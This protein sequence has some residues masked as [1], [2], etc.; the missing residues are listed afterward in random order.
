M[1]KKDK[2]Q[3]EMQMFDAMPGADPIEPDPEPIDL[4]FGLE[5]NDDEI[6]TMADV[7]NEDEVE[8]T[9]E[10]EVAE[11]VEEVSEEEVAD[12]ME[13]KPPILQTMHLSH[14]RRRGTDERRRK[15]RR[16]SCTR[17]RHADRRR[18]AAERSDETLQT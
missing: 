18:C 2:Q 10:E 12:E 4:S 3:E 16:R 15:I 1:A 11:E 8:K 14:C 9:E 17:G 13:L 7:V 6:V 5:T